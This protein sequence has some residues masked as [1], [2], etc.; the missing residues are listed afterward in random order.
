MMVLVGNSTHMKKKNHKGFCGR[1]FVS[2]KTKLE[3][4]YQGEEKKLYTQGEKSFPCEGKRKTTSPRGRN[5][6]VA[7]FFK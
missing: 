1:K 4:S 3:K 2:P 7:N 6:T 5:S